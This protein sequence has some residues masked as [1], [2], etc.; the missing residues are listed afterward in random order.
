MIFQLTHHYTLLTDFYGVETNLEQ[1]ELE[2]LLFYVE[3]VHMK[4]M[5]NLP[6]VLE[7][8]LSED[9]VI[10]LL[11]VLYK[12]T[13]YSFKPIYQKP[14]KEITKIDLWEIENSFPK[15]KSILSEINEKYAIP[16]TTLSLMKFYQT[17]VLASL[18]KDY[19][20]NNDD[21]DSIDEDIKNYHRD[22]ERL[23]KILKGEKILAEWEVSSFV[24]KDLSGIQFIPNNEIEFI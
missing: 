18:K 21:F 24:G 19:A 10:E 15:Y 12:D 13:K 5:P 1:S 14:E 17:E 9:D 23:D 4:H 20:I 8:T 16:D 11:P 2:K 22:A 3:S 7:D 6:Y